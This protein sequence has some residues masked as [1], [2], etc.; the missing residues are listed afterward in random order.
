[1]STAE[2]DQ[3]VLDID[4]LREEDHAVL[5]LMN[6]YTKGTPGL[7]KVL[8]AVLRLCPY[9]TRLNIPR[10]GDTERRRQRRGQVVRLPP[11][12]RT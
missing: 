9:L 7:T 12:A 10:L 11:W 6:F 2:A 8:V 1:M 3:D 4:A 5:V